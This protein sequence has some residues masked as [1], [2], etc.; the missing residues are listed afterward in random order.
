MTADHAAIRARLA[1]ATQGPWTW[2]AH[3][4]EEVMHHV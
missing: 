4:A 3:V 2:A 1:A